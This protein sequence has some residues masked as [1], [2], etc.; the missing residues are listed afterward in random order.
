[1]NCTRRIVVSTARAMISDGVIVS[2]LVPVFLGDACLWWRSGDWWWP[3]RC[4]TVQVAATVAIVLAGEFWISAGKERSC[5]DAECG[6]AETTRT[7]TDAAKLGT[8]R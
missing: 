3:L 1:M 6:T 7:S 2:G 8:A 4:L 5:V